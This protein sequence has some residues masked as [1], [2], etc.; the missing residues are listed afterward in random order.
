MCE[1]LETEKVA[2]RFTAPISFT[3]YKVLFTSSKLTLNFLC[4]P[5]SDVTFVPLLEHTTKHTHVT[6]L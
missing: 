1:L 3:M 2:A 4:R 6:A 5:A